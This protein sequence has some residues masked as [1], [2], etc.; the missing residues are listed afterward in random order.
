M[1][2]RYYSIVYKNYSRFLAFECLVSRIEE[3]SLF[4]QENKTQEEQMKG[5]INI[6][7]KS[8]INSFF[9]YDLITRPR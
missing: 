5:I 8:E 1:I 7:R 4:I 3:A 2:F 6:L 9:Y